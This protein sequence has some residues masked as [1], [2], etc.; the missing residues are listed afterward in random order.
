MSAALQREFFEA[1]QQQAV[2]QPQKDYGE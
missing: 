1:G 2:H